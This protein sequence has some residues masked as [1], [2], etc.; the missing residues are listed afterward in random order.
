M[1]WYRESD[2]Y[3]HTEMN[4]RTLFYK[5]IMEK[6]INLACV[7]NDFTMKILKTTFILFVI[8]ICN[9]SC[10]DNEDSNPVS[11]TEEL[12]TSGRWYAESQTDFTLDDCGKHSNFR[13]LENGNFV[14]ESFDDSSGSCEMKSTISGTWELLSDTQMTITFEDTTI[15]YTIVTISEEELVVSYQSGSDTITTILDK[16]PGNG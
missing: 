8:S 9:F 10:S 14:N 15:T 16:N 2:L 13:F 1:L 3:N 11:M 6:P 5:G 7:K 12:I 4:I